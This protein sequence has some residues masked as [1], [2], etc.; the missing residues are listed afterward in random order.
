[1][2]DTAGTD[3]AP[4]DAESDLS[5]TEWEVQ[6]AEKANA[7]G[8]QPIVFVHGLW[9]LPNS[10]GPWRDV[11]EE[12]GY[13]TAAPGWPDDP[14]TTEEA[15]EHPE[16]LAKKSVGEIAD[17]YE[18]VIRALDKKPAII[19]HSFG[20]LM[21]EILA[22]RGLAVASVPISPAPFRGVLP[23]PYSALKTASV[24]L[25]NPANR[26]RAVPLTYDQFRYSF[27]NMLDD[28]EATE[29]YE[30]YSVPGPGKV[31]FQGALA[32]VAPHSPVAVDFGNDERAPLLLIAGGADH[33]S[34]ESLTESNFKHYR[35]SGAVT[36]FKPFPGRSH[37]TLGQE[38]WEEVADYALDWAAEH[39]KAPAP[40]GHK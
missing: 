10:W 3:D 11:F 6:E 5:I 9:L 29:L 34:P 24:A 38:G 2:S 15:K 31:L 7:T 14:E 4:V 21:T 36:E 20:G 27:A 18:E 30:K 25:R 40:A 19:G 12:A 28:D 37:F 13:V 1:M 23:L 33:V 26:N 35:K 22:G 17:H 39:A 32:N 16:V 8:K